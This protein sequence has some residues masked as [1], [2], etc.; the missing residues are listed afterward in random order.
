MNR[1]GWGGI[2]STQ[3]L[4]NNTLTKAM[5]VGGRQGGPQALFLLVVTLELSM[6]LTRKR[7][8]TAPSGAHTSA[9]VVHAAV[10][11]QNARGLLPLRTETAIVHNA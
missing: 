6:G 5:G 8:Q 1:E 10:E 7:T 2:Q 4:T 11:I 9:D 3:Q